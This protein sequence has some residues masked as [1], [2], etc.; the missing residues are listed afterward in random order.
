MVAVH[1][2]TFPIIWWHPHSDAPLLL[3]FAEGWRCAAARQAL[4]K[5][6]AEVRAEHGRRLDA[7]LAEAEADAEP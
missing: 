1:S 6:V 5:A 3:E 4:D 7:L 2:H